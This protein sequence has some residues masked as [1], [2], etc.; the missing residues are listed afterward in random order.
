MDTVPV[1]PGAAGGAGGCMVGTGTKAQIA[2]FSADGVL[3]GQAEPG[4]A[5]GKQSGW[6]DNHACVAVNRD[7]RDGLLDVFAED[8]YVLR[9]G[10]YRVDDAKL[11]ALAQKVVILP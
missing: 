4:A 6:F 5:M 7:S 8:D 10:W 1:R 3:V 2:H 9:L 11:T